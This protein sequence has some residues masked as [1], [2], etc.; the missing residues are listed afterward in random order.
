MHHRCLRSRY[1]VYIAGAEGAKW[2]GGSGRSGRSE[3]QRRERRWR[4]TTTRVV[5]AKLFLLIAIYI[6]LTVQDLII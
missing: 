5:F 6:D 3:R 1:T 2:S 4:T